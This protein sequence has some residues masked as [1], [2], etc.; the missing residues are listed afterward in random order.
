MAV[1]RRTSLYLPQTQSRS[2]IA[3]AHQSPGFWRAREIRHTLET[4][5]ETSGAELQTTHMHFIPIVVRGHATRDICQIQIE[6]F[7]HAHRKIVL[8]LG[9]RPSLAEDVADENLLFTQ[10]PGYVGAI[11]PRDVFNIFFISV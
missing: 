10:L 5:Q 2:D 4:H 9:L 3:E 1:F 8:P 6:S 7:F 11:I